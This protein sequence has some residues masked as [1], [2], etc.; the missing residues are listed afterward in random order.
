MSEQSVRTLS[1]ID[2]MDIGEISSTINKIGQFQKVVQSQLTQNHD[3]GVIP[4]TPK[5][6]LLKPG[7]EKIIMLLGLR[8]EFDIVDSTRD[9]EKGF[10]QYQVK[11]KL[12]RGD[13]LVTEG[14]G[15]CNNRERKYLKMDP[16]TMDNTVL[17]MAKKR[18]LVDAALL[19][20]SLSDIFTQD[21]EDMDLSGEKVTGRKR[22]ATDQDGTISR[23]QAKRMFALAKGDAD[24]V[25]VALEKRGYKRSEEV[26]KTEYDAICSEIETQAAMPDKEER[27]PGEDDD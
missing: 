23:A 8:S 12:F 22:Y 6:T 10:F 2:S 9:F 5:P 13:M 16:Y 24:I 21:L 17:K 3:Y 4:G 19:V 27:Q 20:G 1:V 11:C 14:L 18:A 7:A 25:R 26:K 15:S